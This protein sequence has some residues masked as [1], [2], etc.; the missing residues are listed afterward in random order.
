MDGDLVD[1]DDDNT[2][3]DH[4][5]RTERVTTGMMRLLPLPRQ[6]TDPTTLAHALEGSL[7][8]F[9]FIVNSV[10]SLFYVIKLLCNH[11]R[12]LEGKSWVT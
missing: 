10:Q 12:V 2:D 1:P 9:H 11:Q 3:L 6:D 5:I 7:S 4:N 8:L